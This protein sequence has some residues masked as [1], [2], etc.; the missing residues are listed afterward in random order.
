MLRNKSPLFKNIRFS[1][2]GKVL[3]GPPSYKYRE[4]RKNKDTLFL[5]AKDLNWDEEKLS[6]LSIIKVSANGNCYKISETFF[7]IFSLFGISF[8][9]KHFKYESIQVMN[10]RFWSYMSIWK[11]RNRCLTGC[12]LYFIS[13]L[14]FLYKLGLQYS[15]VICL[16][17]SSSPLCA[18]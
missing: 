15:R 13:S 10:I 12:L 17:F 14:S 5:Y 6:S 18:L 8:T 7:S 1:F 9:T 11:C 3:I 4:S 16:K 2:G